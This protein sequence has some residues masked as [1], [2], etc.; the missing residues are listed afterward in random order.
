M[1][2]AAIDCSEISRH[3]RQNPIRPQPT[4]TQVDPIVS[5]LPDPR[6]V[7]VG[8]VKSFGYNKASSDQSGQ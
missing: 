3:H 2:H 4:A 6:Q 1:P 7:I 5:D 8:T